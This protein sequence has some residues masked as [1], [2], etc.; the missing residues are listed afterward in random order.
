MAF[1]KTIAAETLDLFE[2][3]FGE[4]TRIATAYHSFD[5]LCAEFVD[6]TQ[7]AECRHG[8]PESVG[9]RRCEPG[10]HDGELHRLFLEQRHALC[11]MKYVVKLVRRSMFR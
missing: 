8:A 1:G 11:F 9:F 5:H 3:A 6:R 10:R 7:I 4:I 2:A